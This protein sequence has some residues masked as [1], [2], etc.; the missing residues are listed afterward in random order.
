[1]SMFS[2][3]FNPTPTPAP[4]PEAP[5]AVP[6]NQGNIPGTPA[7]TVDATGVPVVPAVPVEDKSPLD[8][9]AKLWDTTPVDPK[10]P[11]SPE[12]YKPATAEQIQESVK[13]ADF[14]GSITPEQLALV[15]AGGEDATKALMQIV[16]NVGQQTLA[17]STL[18][19]QKLNQ[20]AIE[21]YVKAEV[22]K[23]PDAMR[24][25]SAANHLKTEN[26]IFSNP[27]IKPVMEMVHQQL[28]GKHPNATDAELT[29]MTQKWAVGFA[30]DMAPK[31]VVDT[32]KATGDDYDWRNYLEG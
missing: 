28:L 23:L 16:N 9:F 32:T 26:P 1:M 12:A 21:S 5:A 30:A 17:Q 8:P 6:P 22:A 3:I 24:Q 4:A 18:V 27:A 25:Q 15:T 7:V 10:A 29:D 19:S 31:S 11:K 20:Q 2:R 14:I 13:K